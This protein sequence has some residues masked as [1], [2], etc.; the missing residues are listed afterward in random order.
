MALTECNT[1]TDLHDQEIN[2]HGDTGFPIACYAD[3]LSQGDVPWH[4]HEEWEFA[5]VTEG[6]PDFRVE[7]RRMTIEKGNGIFINGKA[8]H[9][10]YNHVKYPV[11][12][13]SMCFQPRLIG[14]TVDSVFWKKLV[15]PVSADSGFL[16]LILK[17]DVDW[18]NLALQ[19][20]ERAWHAVEAESEDFENKVRYELSHALH[21][22]I[23]NADFSGTTLSE[24]ELLNAGRIRSMLEYIEMHYAEDLAVEDIANAVSISSSACLRCFRQMIGN[25]PM[26]Y[27]KQ[28][29]I[30]KAAEL[31]ETTEKTAQDIA[32]SCGFNDVSYFTKTFKELLGCTPTQYRRS[33]REKR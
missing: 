1:I 10:V 8:L 29:R 27:V 13:H 26:Q 2:K 15:Q 5:F 23:S 30:R 19:A 17:A 7:N 16:F 28:L 14:G 20:F 12:L 33:F 25:S 32:L 24:Q 31:L 9:A 3:D 4:W 21:L 22:I 6:L 18:Q 11:R